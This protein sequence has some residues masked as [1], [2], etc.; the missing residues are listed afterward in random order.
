ME[1]PSSPLYWAFG[2]LFVLLLLASLYVEVL[3]YRRFAADRFHRRLAR[4]YAGLIASF[5]GLGFAATLFA[6]LTVP[7]LSKRIWLAGAVVGLAA[8]LAH[9]VWYYR[10]RYPSARAAYEKADRRRRYLPRPRRRARRG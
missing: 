4:R 1:P 6:F 5:S 8:S 9:A 10:G 2:G 3:T 7:F